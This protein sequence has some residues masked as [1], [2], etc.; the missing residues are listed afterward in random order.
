M[1]G[2]HHLIQSPQMGRPV[3]LWKYG[4]FG[5][6]VLAFP[7]AAGMAHEWQAHGMV[8]ALSPLLRAGK[9]KLYCPE[10]NVAAAWTRKDAPPAERIRRHE[11]YERFVMQTLVPLIYEDCR[12][13]GI[14]IAAAGCSLG[15]LYA[16]NSVLKFPTVF[17]WGLCM[18]GRY[19]VRG[20]TDGHDDLS[21]YFSNP[22]AYV[23]N[24]HGD[25]LRRIR[26]KTHL[27]IV[28]GRGKWEEGCIEETM[29]M[30]GIFQSKNIP[31]ECDL[32]GYDSAH[33]WEWWRR[34]AVFHMDRRF[35]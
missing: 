9:I 8:E 35:G 2:T 31:H 3:H 10:S 20:F 5:L 4:H 22:M 12:T 26:E 30:A 16:M 15:A 27:T 6:P 32:W 21:V 29:A 7:S 1:Q 25:P 11:A 34:Q 24:L 33:D 18:S 14:P 23:S 17:N 19:E 28:C 13:E